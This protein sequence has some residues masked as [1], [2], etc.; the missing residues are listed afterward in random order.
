MFPGDMVW[1]RMTSVIESALLAGI[2]LMLVA[3][4]LFLGAILLCLAATAVA[5]LHARYRVRF[6]RSVHGG[7]SPVASRGSVRAGRSSHG[8]APRIQR[9]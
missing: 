5:G 8:F 9:S 1:S 2:A 7:R 3:T 6:P 4:L